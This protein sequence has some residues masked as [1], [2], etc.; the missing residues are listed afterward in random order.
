[1]INS[2]I[3]LFF[4]E[5]PFILHLPKW[6]RQIPD[7]RKPMCVVRQ[8]NNFGGLFTKDWYQEPVSKQICIVVDGPNRAQAF[9]K[10][11]RTVVP[12]GKVGIFSS[13]GV[14]LEQSAPMCVDF[15]LDSSLPIGDLFE[16]AIP[17][18]NIRI[19]QPSFEALHERRI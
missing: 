6:Q 10:F 15:F 9:G 12:E 8:N 2:T 14:M 4:G 19:Y 13:L 3:S 18:I 17:P 7:V 1:L 5:K 16:G 11:A